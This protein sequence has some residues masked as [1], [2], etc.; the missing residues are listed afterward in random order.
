MVASNSQDSNVQPQV[1]TQTTAP[2]TAA[3][4]QA[5]GTPTN[6]PS[7]AAVVP[8]ET[9]PQLA[10]EPPNNTISPV[11]TTDKMAIAMLWYAVGVYAYSEAF[12]KAIQ[13]IKTSPN[14]NGL[15][16]IHTEPESKKIPVSELATEISQSKNTID[17]IDSA[18][19]SSFDGETQ[20]DI[21]NKKEALGLNE[22]TPVQG[23]IA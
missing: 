6:P 10:T 8:Q 18:I 22:E 11:A 2:V 4:S 7:E 13:D 15:F 9:Q 17:M 23:Q 14:G 16:T 3:V 21:E 5:L 1:P 19:N 20:Q 12:N